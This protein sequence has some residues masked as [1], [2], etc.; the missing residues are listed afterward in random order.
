MSALWY[1]PFRWNDLLSDWCVYSSR[2]ANDRP[3]GPWRLPLYQLLRSTRPA[4]REIQPPAAPGATQGVV[5]GRT[6]SR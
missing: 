4:E 5:S 6:I 3:K 1:D 2:H